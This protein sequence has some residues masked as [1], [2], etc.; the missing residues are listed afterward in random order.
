MKIEKENETNLSF[1]NKNLFEK[2]RRNQGCMF[3][4]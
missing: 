3:E 1:T 4:A 2:K